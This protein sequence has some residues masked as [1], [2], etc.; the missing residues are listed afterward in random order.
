MALSPGERLG[1]YEI[2][3]PIGAG[4]MG[5]VYR[6][7]DTR[8]GRDVALKVLPGDFL[9]DKERRSRFE[10]EAKVLAS[11]NHPGI[12]AIYAFEE[13]TGSSPS[14]ARHLLAMELL[15]GETLADRL[16]RGRLPRGQVVA[17][18]SQI[19]SALEAAHR[20]G[21]VHRDL[22]PGNIML[23]ASGV[24]LLD[25]GLAKAFAPAGSSEDV[26]S[27]PT[28]AADVTRDG[29][30]LGTPAYLA[31]EQ[32]QG[33]PADARS[34][35]FA[36]GAV[37]YEMATG[38]K[39]FSGPTHASVIGAILTSEPPDVSTISPP[40]PRALDRIVR[41]C[42]AKDPEERWQ[43]ARD[44]GLQLRA[45]AEDEKA[46]PAAAAPGR[47]R[48]LE[49]L[50]W[51]AVALTAFGSAWWLGKQSTVRPAPSRSV[52]FQVTAPEGASFNVVGRDAGPVVVSPD[53]GRLAFIAT[54][55]EGRK[56]LFVRSLDN[57]R[58]EPLA[59][60]DGASFP[61]WSPDSRFIGFFAEG[62]LKK[63]PA[64][65][66][67]T[68]VLAD[69]PLGRG[70]TWSREDV[71]VYSPNIYDPLYRVS[72]AGGNAR[73]LTRV[74]DLNQGLSHRWPCFLPDGRHYLFVKWG[75]P[76]RSTRETDAV[77]AGDLDSDEE[78]FLFKASSPVIYA[79]PGYLLY[80]RD[81]TLMAVPFDAAS[82]RLTGTPVPLAA[83]V[84]FYSNTGSGAFS[85]SENGVLAYQAGAAPAVSQLNWYDRE[86][87]PV[88]NVGTPGDF[89]DPRI[90]P[91]GSAVA[92]NR[93]DP[94]AGTTNIWLL[95]LGRGS[96]E[97]FTF[98]A[99]FDHYP[100]WSPDG[101]RIAFDTNRNG[102]ADLYWK[103]VSGNSGEEEL[104]HS[105]E[106][107]SPTDWSPDGKLLIY[108][109]LDPKTKYD[110]WALPVAGGGKPVPL[111]R[112]GANETD[113]RVS[114]D[115]R[116]IAYAS[117]ESG[118][119]EVYVASF[120]GPGGRW[121]LS[122]EGGTEPVWRRDGK[123]LFY[124]GADRKLM[125]VPIT[126]GPRFEFGPPHALFQTRARYT[127]NIAYDVAPDGQRFL[128]N[129]LVGS[130]AIPP[131]TVVMNWTTALSR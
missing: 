80:L 1:P 54:T 16:R 84:L 55:S 94:V 52:R 67:P 28:A 90:S 102:A 115:G 87:R 105:G 116:W 40:N 39:A 26:S 128:V 14:S 44:V 36:L 29:A 117:D 110:L 2:V 50:A 78:T 64:T 13:I 48:S 27:G 127:G 18:G 125:A 33:R 122:S 5:E 49:R 89:E 43:S 70:G 88:G 53:G 85:A 106:A 83:R 77:F 34:D 19:C 51:T 76:P 59:G 111:L 60:T 124:L 21:I 11:L 3:A 107:K 4:G 58:A 65:G 12:A 30:I 57:L 22:K 71:I 62:K 96:A 103:V 97:R 17:L 8:L 93:I 69:A 47:G 10:R 41:G 92:V 95:G 81:E 91:D 108:E 123:E 25:F 121:Q 129:T 6:A 74:I 75:A 20:K 37:L 56:L 100:V 113:G 32:L 9:E 35:V 79:A 99:S 24:K 112:S 119:R 126:G 66:G 42:L 23:T 7:T 114:P 68:Q 38:T 45:M 46:E 104:L 109:Q 131:I 120:P 15:E 86:G 130:E 73:R 63:V 98:S 72:S 101:R 61:F 82:R 118:R 31:P